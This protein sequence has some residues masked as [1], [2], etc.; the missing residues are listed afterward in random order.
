MEE[1]YATGQRLAHMSSTQTS[2]KSGKMAKQMEKIRDT[3]LGS[4]AR[5]SLEYTDVK[6]SLKENDCIPPTNIYVKQHEDEN[7]MTITNVA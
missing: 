4:Q 5:L 2:V 3:W 6:S 1:T 7:K